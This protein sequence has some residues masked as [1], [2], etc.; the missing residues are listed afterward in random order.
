MLSNYML[1]MNTPNIRKAFSLLLNIAALTQQ[2]IRIVEKHVNKTPKSVYSYIID[3][4]LGYYKIKNKSK[5]TI[6]QPCLR[7]VIV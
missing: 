6:K 7:H 5:E 3:K 2:H 4:L 1:K